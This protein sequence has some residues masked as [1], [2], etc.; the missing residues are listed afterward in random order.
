MPTCFETLMIKILM[1]LVAKSF[2]NFKV[3]IKISGQDINKSNP[4]L[5]KL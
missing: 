1:Y 2:M 3:Y 5:I 4:I